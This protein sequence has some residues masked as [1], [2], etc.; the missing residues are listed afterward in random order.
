LAALTTTQI[1]SLGLVTP[2]V[3]DLNGDGIQTLS[4]NAGVKFDILA[5]GNAIQTGWVGQQDGLL[6]SDKNR[7]GLINDGTELFGSSTVL[8]N[9]QNAVDGYQALAQFDSNSDGVVNKQD[10]DFG[11]L[12]VWVDGNSDGFT[13]HGELKSLTEAGIKQISLSTETVRD[14]NEGNLIGLSSIYQTSDGQHRSAADVWF[15]VDKNDENT[16]SNDAKPSGANLLSKAISEFKDR[17]SSAQPGLINSKQEL[18]SDTSLTELTLNA[19]KLGSALRQYQLSTVNS[20]LSAINEGA[21]KVNLA[22]L[23]SPVSSG[24]EKDKEGAAA[25]LIAQLQNKGSSYR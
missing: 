19:D 9:G 18:Q 13:G 2:I 3:L 25:N 20:A 7:D 16:L 11:K 14:S 22:M 15:V 12:S 21:N 6:V 1:G 5:N 8:A 23:A 24:P 17:D 10:L 4:F